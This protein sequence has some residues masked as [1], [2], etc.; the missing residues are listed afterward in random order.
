MYENK[1]FKGKL[2]RS[3]FEYLYFEWFRDEGGARNFKD[4]LLHICIYLCTTFIRA[5]FVYTFLHIIS[6]A[7]TIF[8]KFSMHGV[9]RAINLK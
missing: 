3:A 2:K 9:S 5:I 8:I 1:E 7:P 4:L 6:M